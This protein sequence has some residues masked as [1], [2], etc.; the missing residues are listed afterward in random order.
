[1][2]NWA[3]GGVW[4]EGGRDL[5]QPVGGELAQWVQALVVSLKSSVPPPLPFLFF[6][7][8]TDNEGVLFFT[9]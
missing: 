9:P 5:I 6:S 4:V 3:E 8:F 7:P 1:M 2:G